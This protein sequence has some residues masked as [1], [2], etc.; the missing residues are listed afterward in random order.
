MANADLERRMAEVFIDRLHA[1]D[2]ERKRRLTEA[3]DGTNETVLVRTTFELAANLRRR[4]TKAVHDEIAR[5][6]DVEYETSR[7]ISCGIELKAGS[8]VVT[9]SLGGYLDEIEEQLSERI[10]KGP[11]SREYRKAG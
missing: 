2:G 11:Q 4:L 1:M 6:A 5:D 8:Q 10:R 3:V 7:D 9:W